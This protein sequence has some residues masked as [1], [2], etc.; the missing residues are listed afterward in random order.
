MDYEKELKEAISVAN[1]IVEMGGKFEEG[2]PYEHY[3]PLEDENGNKYRMKI[4]I[5]KRG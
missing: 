3:I 4:I 2:F 5:E 1:E